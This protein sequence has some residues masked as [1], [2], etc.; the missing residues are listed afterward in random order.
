MEKPL[1]RICGYDSDKLVCFRVYAP[2]TLEGEPT[3]RASRNFRPGCELLKEIRY[4]IKVRD[5]LRQG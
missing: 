5:T 2:S 1:W 4:Q 3:Y